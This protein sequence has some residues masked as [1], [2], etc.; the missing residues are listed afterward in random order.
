MFDHEIDILQQGYMAQ[1][2]AAHGDNVSVFPFADRTHLAIYAHQDRRPVAGASDRLH[3]R[4]AKLVHP[5]IQL[6]PGRLAVE[7]HFPLRAL[8]L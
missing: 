7:F 5:H 4:N 8:Y 2:I 6:V 1:N 3:S